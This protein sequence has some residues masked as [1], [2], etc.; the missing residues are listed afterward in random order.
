MIGDGRRTYSD[1]TL[2]SMKKDELI[3]VIRCLEGNL[4]GA[5]ETLDI[6]SDNVK[7]LLGSAEE[8]LMKYKA[9]LFAIVRT[10]IVIPRFKNK[11][12]SIAGL[13]IATI[14][15]MAML[16]KDLN[17]DALAESYLEA[18]EVVKEHEGNDWKEVN[19]ILEKGESNGKN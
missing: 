16:F 18:L 1:S 13:D 3:D 8:E 11:N 17:T 4:Q 2:Q 7:K 6:Q 5:N 9:A 10:D 14:H 19:G 12:I 15:S